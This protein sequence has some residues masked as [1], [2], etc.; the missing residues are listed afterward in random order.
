M[1]V[2]N[3]KSP[4]TKRTT[5][6][7]TALASAMANE[8]SHMQDFQ[9]HLHECGFTPDKLRGRFRLAGYVFGL[10]SRTRGTGWVLRT[11]IWAENRVVEHHGNCW[12]ALNGTTRPAR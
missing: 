12:Q 1:A 2:N 5:P 4:M 9:T 7:N 6:F 11:G 10:G 8:M 3:F